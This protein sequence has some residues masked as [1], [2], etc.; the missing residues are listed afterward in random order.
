VIRRAVA[1][2]ARGLLRVA[3]RSHQAAA[4]AIFGNRPEYYGDSGGLTRRECHRLERLPRLTHTQ[5]PLLSNRIEVTDPYWY[6]VMYREIIVD[7]DYTFR[8]DSTSP[9]ILDCGA[10]IGVSVAF[11]RH[12]FPAA[13]IIA[14]EPDPSVYEV[15]KRNMARY[16]WDNTDLRNSAVWIEEGPVAFHSDGAV[17]GR[18][19]RDEAEPG[20]SR[21]RAERLYDYLDQ[22]VDMLKLDIEGAELDVL[23]DCQD[24]LCNVANLFVE[25]HGRPTG[26]QRLAVLLELLQSAGY[27]YYVKDAWPVRQ[28][29]LA[30]QRSRL[31][32]L[33]LNVFAYRDSGSVLQ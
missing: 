33:Q 1:S 11:F 31:Y 18:L 4:L 21:V 15:L 29:F 19:T 27:R 30:S 26:H 28:P 3:W 14:F 9:L 20:A 12:R 5:T 23:A 22:P 17:G 32:D 10:N 25:Y 13:R 16:S 24:R 2:I 6:L 8:S 7:G